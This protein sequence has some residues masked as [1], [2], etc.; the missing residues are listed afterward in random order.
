MIRS[1]IPTISIPISRIQSQVNFPTLRFNSSKPP[2]SS[3]SS[4]SDTTSPKTEDDSNNAIVQRFQQILDE[5]L[6]S[7]SSF[8]STTSNKSIMD[9]DPH[10]KQL[11]NKYKQE[12]QNSDQ[13]IRAKA[14]IKSEP[15]LKSNKHARDIF[16]SQ[17]WKG[18]ESDFDASLRMIIDS[19]PKA[20]ST[21]SKQGRSR[22][23][24]TIITPPVSFREK[25][26]NAKESSFDYKLKK[27]QLKD[28]KSQ[29]SEDNFREMYK[30]RLLGP[31]MLINTNNPST[32]IDLV[33]SLASNKINA[34]INQSTGQFD[35]P[36]MIHVRGK[37]LDIQHLKNCTDSNYFM[38]QVLNNQQVLPPWI[39][40]QQS[41]NGMIQSFRKDVDELWFKWLVHRSSLTPTIENQTST[42]EIVLNSFQYKLSNGQFQYNKDLLLTSDYNYL[43][44]KIKLINTNIRNYN[45]QSPSSSLHKFKLLLDT[46]IKQSFKNNLHTFPQNFTIWFEKH[47][48]AKSNQK[49]TSSSS[50]GMLNL[51][52]NDDTTYGTSSSANL[53]PLYITRP[54][55]D[56][57]LHLWKAIK[58]IFK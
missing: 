40:S 51:F 38:N 3:S 42:V 4:S 34:A 33:N 12:D 7:S 9:S 55:V 14:Y 53:T 39:E 52:G 15:L 46:E 56:N 10:L 54:G 29:E 11:Y 19:K 25:V 17:P 48:L 31:T 57:K 23:S 35:S 49:V 44:E 32:T 37:P 22:G 24:P 58:D 45:L 5:Q 13:I 1:K 21:P 6:S 26:L 47:K 16:E 8:T 36:D 50:G 20:K 2:S 28:N 30:E 27:E 18:K 43:Q 41:L